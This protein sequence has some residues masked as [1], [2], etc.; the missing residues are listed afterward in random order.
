MEKRFARWLLAATSALLVAGCSPG[1]G[2]PPG[3]ID[4]V[5]G[6]FDPSYDYRR[7]DDD[8]WNHDDHRYDRRYACSEDDLACS[9]DGRTICC[10]RSDGCCAGSGGP[11]CCGD[12]YAR[13][14]DHHSD[15]DWDWPEE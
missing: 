3:P 14:H 7:A 1:G 10:S 9:H 11:Y 2:P 5:R 12:G 6:I 4:I 15:R 8:S 13:R